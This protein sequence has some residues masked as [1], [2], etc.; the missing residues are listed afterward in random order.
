M[1]KL[2]EDAAKDIIKEKGSVL[3]KTNNM[4]VRSFNSDKKDELIK[5]LVKQMQQLLLN[6]IVATSQ[7][8]QNMHN[9][10]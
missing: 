9:K 8:E 10:K 6:Y 7:Q 5:A 4:K 1:T 3:K 2:F